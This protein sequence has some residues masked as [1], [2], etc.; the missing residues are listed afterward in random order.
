MKNLIIYSVLATS[1]LA[2]SVSAVAQVG[3]PPA[4]TS[5]ITNKDC[6]AIKVQ[7]DAMGIELK[8]KQNECDAIHKELL[9]LSQIQQEAEAKA[10]QPNSTVEDGYAYFNAR[11]A[12]SVKAKEYNACSDQWWVIFRGRANLTSKCK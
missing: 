2:A 1:V 4:T 3:A 5:A 12:T 9:S 10:N 8:N 11:Q 7:W 6:S